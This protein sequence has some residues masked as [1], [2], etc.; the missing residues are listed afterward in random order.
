MPRA[1]VL[2]HSEQLDR[3]ARD[4]PDAV[5]NAVVAGDPRFDR[6]TASLDLRARYRAALGVAEH[7]RLVLLSSTWSSR[8]LFGAW[9]ELFRQVLAELPVDRYRVAGVLHPHVHYGHG[10][11]QVRLWLADCLRAGLLLVPPAEGWSAAVI[12][13]DV[14]VGDHGAVTCYGAAIDRPVL[15]A[16]FP[17]E[18]VAAGSCV[19]ELG[20]TA[21]M[22]DGGTPL[23][24]QI[25]DAVTGHEPGRYHRVRDLVSSLPGAAAARHRALGYALLGLAEPEH[26]ALVP[27]LSTDGLRPTEAGVAALRVS[28]EVDEAGTVTLVRHPADVLRG[29]ATRHPVQVDPHLVVHTDHPSPALRGAADIVFGDDADRALERHPYCAM[30]ASIH[31]DHA[32]V[33]TRRNPAARIVVRSTGADPLACV[34]AL[35]LWQTHRADDPPAELVVDLG[36]GPP[37][38]VTVHTG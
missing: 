15:L 13:A 36:S 29:R 33:V 26:D 38:R 16:A 12:A 23:E 3:L 28:G 30:A 20:G 31:H 25:E 5:P 2:S 34:S 32:R 6:I 22:L 11:R 14:V 9:P 8:S 1:L 7:E 10:R 35:Y 24:R 17:A 21:P 27:V 4:V 18:D 37:C 19:A